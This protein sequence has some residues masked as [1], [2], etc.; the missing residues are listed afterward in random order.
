MLYCGNIYVYI[1]NPKSKRDT[2]MLIVNNAIHGIKFAKQNIDILIKI[3]G[4][5]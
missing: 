3:K 5:F 1:Y 4:D 2:Y